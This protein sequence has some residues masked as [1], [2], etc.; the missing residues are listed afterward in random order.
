MRNDDGAADGAAELVALELIPCWR[1]VVARVED[2]VA[3]EFEQVAVNAIVARLRNGVDHRAGVS[4][5]A[6]AVVAALHAELLERI[7]EGKRH[8]HVGVS[9]VVA[10]AI[11]VEAGLVRA[12]AVE[13]DGDCG[14]KRLG[15]T[16]IDARRRADRG[17][18]HKKCER[19]GIS[20]IDG[21]VDDALL[22]NHLAEHGGRGIDLDGVRLHGDDLLLAT[23]RQRGT[24]GQ[25]LIGK[26]GDAGLLEG[27]EA[28]GLD[29]QGV[30]G[31]VE[32]RDD[33]IPL[34]IRFD[35][36]RELSSFV[37]D[38]DIRVGKHGAGAVGDGT[39]D[40]AESLSRRGA[41]PE[42][43]DKEERNA[44]DPSQ[45]AI[46]NGENLF[47]LRGEGAP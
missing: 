34:T 26:E 20:A 27:A 2:G 47:A 5:I 41:G 18:G 3:D 4:A 21:Q 32:R 46:R 43:H 36:T 33:V 45:A 37:D 44:G 35:L 38:S 28:A 22:L 9:V 17:A 15:D 8:V 12:R 40:R 31:G 25:T 19:D 23:D 6:S 39:D 7:R 14:G 24:D 1:K 13:R 42:V 11:H 10:T 16:L 30:D 29:R